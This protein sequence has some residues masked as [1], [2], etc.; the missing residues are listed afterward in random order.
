MINR[1][2]ESD[3]V[4]NVV[5]GRLS[6]KGPKS[7]VTELAPIIRQCKSELMTI[8]SEDWTDD[9]LLELFNER[10]AIAEYDGE[11]DRSSAE[12][13]AM[14]FVENT[15]GQ[16]RYQAWSNKP[17]IQNQ[18]ALRSVEE[19]IKDGRQSCRTDDRVNHYIENGVTNNE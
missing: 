10:A 19:Y 11:L 8:L 13:A 7:L 2:L 1:I 16:R 4:L 12:A 18:F 6:V 3:L 17:T 9:E 5:D 14:A 15:V